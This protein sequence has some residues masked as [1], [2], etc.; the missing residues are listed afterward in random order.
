MESCKNST[1]DLVLE[2]TSAFL[3][4][5]RNDNGLEVIDSRNGHQ[6]RLLIP[7]QCSKPQIQQ[8]HSLPFISFFV[9]LVQIYMYNY[10]KMKTDKGISK[11]EN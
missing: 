1:G 2:V 4:R 11:S 10:L 3:G 5:R 6:T 7:G 8:Q 9:E